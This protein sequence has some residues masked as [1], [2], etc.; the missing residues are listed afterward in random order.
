MLT[1]LESKDGSPAN[2]AESASLAFIGVNEGDYFW[3]VALQFPR[4]CFS[5]I[6]VLYENGHE[7]PLEVVENR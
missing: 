6:A 2:L 5:L 1:A 7:S 3:I 4:I